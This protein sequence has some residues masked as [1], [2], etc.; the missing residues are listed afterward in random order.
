MALLTAYSGERAWKGIRDSLRRPS[1]LSRVDHVRKTWDR[2]QSTDIGSYCF[3]NRTIKNCN[4]L[5]AE[6]LGTFPCNV[7][8][9]ET[10]L[11]KQL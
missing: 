1:Y 6:M 5:P 10:E 2:K 8:F 9:L 3:V 4:Q 11:E 7:N